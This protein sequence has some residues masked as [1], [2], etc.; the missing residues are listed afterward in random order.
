MK[1]VV[2]IS[3]LIALI[4]GLALF[5]AGNAGRSYSANPADADAYLRVHIRANSNGAR[6]QEV[7]Y[8]VRDEVVAYLTP[9]VAEC[10][11]KEEAI[12]KIE[13]NLDGASLI[14][15]RT[16]KQ[17]G[18]SYGARASIRREEFPTRIYEGV[19][20]AAGVYDA[21]ILELGAG[22]GDNWWCVV[23]PP[24]C[25]GSGNCKVEYKSKIAE[26]VRR[27]FAS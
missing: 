4:A 18:Y 17:Y 11:T 14:A 1:K 19:T 3:F 21:L 9:I 27:F 8:K 7:K 24:L 25:F 2:I 5:F 6:D 15:D 26:I 23:Y 13:Q 16:L 12:E 22:E 10:N 20:L